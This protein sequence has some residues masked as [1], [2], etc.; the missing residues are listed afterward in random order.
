MQADIT[1]R[2]KRPDGTVLIREARVE[3]QRVYRY[4]GFTAETR[5]EFRQR[6]DRHVKAALNATVGGNS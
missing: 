5:K 3:S 6:V 4:G 1:I 2:V